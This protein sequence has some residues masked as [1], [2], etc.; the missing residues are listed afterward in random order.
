MSRL[1]RPTGHSNLACA[2]R[3]AAKSARVSV[4]PERDAYRLL[5]ALAARQYWMREWERR[6]KRARCQASWQ[7]SWQA[8]HHAD[9]WYQEIRRLGAAGDNP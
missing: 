1:V 3:L 9:Q 5:A 2:Y 8:G 7:A 4:W 6:W